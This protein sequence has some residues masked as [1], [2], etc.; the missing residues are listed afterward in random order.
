MVIQF[1]QAK[2]HFDDVRK[3]Y[4]ELE[5]T[6]GVNTTLALRITFDP[7]AIRYNG[8]ERTQALYEEM[9]AVE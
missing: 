7:L 1:D 5:G 8:G 9:M 6:P 2:Q 4:Q 3:R